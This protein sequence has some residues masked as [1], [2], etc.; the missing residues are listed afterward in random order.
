MTAQPRGT[1]PPDEERPDAEDTGPT[2]H[3][4]HLEPPQDDQWCLLTHRSMAR[5]QRATG[6][7]R[8]G[9]S[10]HSPNPGTNTRKASQP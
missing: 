7:T 8:S 6:V 5:H 1:G 4:T 3:L 2:L 10:A 9:G